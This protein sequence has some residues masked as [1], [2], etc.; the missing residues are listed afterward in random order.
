MDAQNNCDVIENTAFGKAFKYCRT[1]KVEAHECPVAVNNEPHSSEW[2]MINPPMNF[3]IAPRY[4]APKREFKAGDK[5][6]VVDCGVHETLLGTLGTIIQVQSTGSIFYIGGGTNDE[7]MYT[8]DTLRGNIWPAK[9]L[10][11]A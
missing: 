10:E 6:K 5:V 3:E 7:P 4:Q 11:H 8:L 2:S 1:H 9:C